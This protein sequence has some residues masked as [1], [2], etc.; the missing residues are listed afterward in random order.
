MKKT[1][2]VADFEGDGEV[3]DVYVGARVR[4]R[5]IHLGL[6]LDDMAMMSGLPIEA[7]KALEDGSAK[8]TASLVLQLSQLL[9]VPVSWFFEGVGPAGELEF[10][11]QARSPASVS[12]LSREAED[13]EKLRFCYQSIG[14]SGLKSI[15][16]AVAQML[17]DYHVTSSN[18]LPRDAN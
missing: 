10:G 16:M 8:V 4:M 2:A 13:L 5:R 1:G 14:N 3:L 11:G 18:T 6:Q 15:L 17:A 7:L 9:E 12:Y